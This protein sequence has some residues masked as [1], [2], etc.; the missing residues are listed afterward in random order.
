MSVQSKAAQVSQNAAAP[1][2]SIVPVKQ[3]RWMHLGVVLLMDGAY[4]VN[5]VEEVGTMNIMFKIYFNKIYTAPLE[6]TVLRA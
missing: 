3:R 6:G 4:I 2:S 5:M 1:A